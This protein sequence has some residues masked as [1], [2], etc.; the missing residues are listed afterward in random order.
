[1]NVDV[2]ALLQPVS[3]A[4]PCGPDL[5]YDP[6]FR[7]I[8]RELDDASQKEKPAE[9]ANVGPAAETAVALLARSK[10]MWIASHGFC[11]ALYSGDLTAC[12]KLL[13]LIAGFA[14]QFWDSCHPALDEG[15][16]PAGGR[17]EACRQLASVARVTRPLERL[18]LQ[19]LKSKGRLSFKDILG[20]AGPETKAADILAQS[21]E[22]IRRAI[23]DTN[24]GEWSAL[25]EQLDI[26][27][28]GSRRISAAFDDKAS[29]QG[30]DL[31]PFDA[32]VARLKGFADAVIARKAPAATA[33]EDAEYS[34]GGGHGEGPALGGPIRSR[35][36]AVSALDA[37]KAFLMAT[38]PSSPAPLLIERAK[39]LIGMDFMQIIENLAPAGLEEALRL[40]QPPAAATAEAPQE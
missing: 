2:E 33:D 4:E 9:D 11:F 6:D 10:D 31:G 14:E 13:E 37:V 8:S 30:P 23:D 12:G 21:P 35:A 36:Q 34:A 22:M 32:A 15:S 7:R 29:G 27:L 19:P 26:I 5:S 17:R 28:Q 20:A 18:Q 1:M 3:E 40:L 16:D 25:S 24:V 38:E 39:R